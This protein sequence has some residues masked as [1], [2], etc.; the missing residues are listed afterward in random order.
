MS[1]LHDTV[2]PDETIVNFTRDRDPEPEIMLMEHIARVYEQK[3]ADRPGNDTAER[4]LLY[5]VLLVRT[6]PRDSRDVVSLLPA[7]K[8]L[9]NLDRVLTRYEE[10]SSG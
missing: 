9:R 8:T 7:A 1:L 5:Q 3:L 2:S 4:S 6:F 10:T